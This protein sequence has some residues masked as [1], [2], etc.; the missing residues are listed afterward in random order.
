MRIGIV[1]FGYMGRMHFANWNRCPDAAVA[2]ICEKNPDLLNDLKKPIGNIA[3]AEQP[4]DLSGVRL[5]STIADLLKNEKLD[6]VSITLPTHF[7]EDAAI[8][9]LNSGVHVLCEKPMALTS[10]Q[11]GRMLAASHAAGRHL[12]IGHCIRFW[13]EYVTAKELID[14]G[15]YGGVLSASFDRLGSAPKWSSGGWLGDASRS[16]GM[17]LD[18]HIHDAD[19]VQSLFGMPAAVCSH[20][21]LTEDRIT[22]ICTQYDYNDGRL[23]TAQGSWLASAT[24]G[25]EMSFKIML[26]Q[27]TLVYNCNHKP[28]LKVY[29]AEGEPFSP[30]L[31]PGD[32]YL[33][34]VA[35]FADLVRG[36]NPPLVI[37][38]EQSRESVRLIEAERISAIEHRRVKL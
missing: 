2:A 19:F 5:Y 20:A 34:E 15:R 26:E 21:A 17:I 37:T 23:I 4:A 1:G 30:G 7:H 36:D 12:M 31:A 33:H 22:H 11:C 14:S 16:G 29:P 6:A 10:A 27:A 9:C 28:A 32:G 38:A 18:L 8:E 3:G 13:P 24:F 25:F 35:W